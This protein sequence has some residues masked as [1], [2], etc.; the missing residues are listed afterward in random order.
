MKCPRCGQPIL[1]RFG[2]RLTPKQVE[3]VERIEARRDGIASEM[4]ASVIY[5]EVPAITARDRIKAHICQ[6][7]DML[8]A[9][10]LRI[11][12]RGGKYQVAR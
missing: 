7:N 8:C 11:V 12:N 2:V 4:L 6:I 9:T 1:N 3:I 10:D 5:P